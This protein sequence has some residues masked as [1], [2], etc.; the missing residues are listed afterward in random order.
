M[1]T[2][3]DPIGDGYAIHRYTDADASG[4]LALWANEQA[5]PED[6]AHRRVDEALLV[7]THEDAGVVGVM[8]AYVQRSPQLDVD[9]WAQ[10]Y[11]VGSD[12]RMANIALHFSMRSLALLEERFVTGEDERG[13]GILYELE[14]ARMMS[15][16]TQAVWPI[17]DAA[18][19]GVNRVGAHVYV[20]YFPGA[21]VL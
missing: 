3:D 5:V 6:E 4:V 10:R 17:V 11:F 9:L 13:I 8:T 16:F 18:F 2:P 15:H 19:V 21:R 7:A 14:N 12:H 1:S 20:R